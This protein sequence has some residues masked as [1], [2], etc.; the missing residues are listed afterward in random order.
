MAFQPTPADQ[1]G[2]VFSEEANGHGHDTTERPNA[3]RHVPSKSKRHR[4]AARK[5]IQNKANMAAGQTKRR[6]CGFLA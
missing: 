2:P 3:D 1:T 5:K 6:S 4:P